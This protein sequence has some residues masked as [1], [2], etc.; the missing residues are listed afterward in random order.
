MDRC[1]PAHDKLMGIFSAGA[2]LRGR[3][4]VILQHLRSSS[5]LLTIRHSTVNT[6]S[7]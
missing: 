6:S 7:A 2:L 5:A 4:S 3:G 1:R